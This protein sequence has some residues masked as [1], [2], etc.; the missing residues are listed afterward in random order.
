MVGKRGLTLSRAI[1]LWRVLG[2]LHV[3]HLS[4]IFFGT[5]VCRNT[6]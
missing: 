3:Y 1:C 2:V 4:S 6:A 5:G